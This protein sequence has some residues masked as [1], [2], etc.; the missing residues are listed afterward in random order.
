MIE[1]EF[2][3]N[4]LATSKMTVVAVVDR[5]LFITERWFMSD[6]RARSLLKTLQMAISGKPGS[7]NQGI[8]VV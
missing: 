2:P 6:Y 7:Q 4:F 3:I 5:S 8:F 1:A